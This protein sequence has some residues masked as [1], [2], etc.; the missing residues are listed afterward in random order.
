[1]CFIAARSG[2]WWRRCIQIGWNPISARWFWRIGRNYRRQRSSP[3]Q[4]S[5]SVTSCATN[6]NWRHSRSSWVLKRLPIWRK[7]IRTSMGGIRERKKLKSLIGLP[8]S[9][10]KSLSWMQSYLRGWRLLLPLMMQKMLL[11]PT[12]RLPLLHAPPR[13]SGQPITLMIMFMLC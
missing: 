2:R 4:I 11:P 5:T 12:A 13:T 3:L 6:A 7:L 1:M 8:Q 10:S 9:S